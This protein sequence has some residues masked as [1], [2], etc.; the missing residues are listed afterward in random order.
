MYFL[1]ECIIEW[2]YEVVQTRYISFRRTFGIAQN[3]CLHSH[4][5]SEAWIF[6]CRLGPI[7]TSK[8][9]LPRLRGSREKRHDFPS[10]IIIPQSTL[11][12]EM[13]QDK[14]W[15]SL[16]LK[17]TMT[18]LNLLYEMIRGQID[19]DVIFHSEV[20]TRGSQRYRYRQDNETKNIYFYSFF[21]RTIRLWNN[22]PAVIVESKS[23][24]IFNYELLPYLAKN[25]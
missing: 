11:L 15:T 2:T 10:T 9:T 23:F 1:S 5:S 20:G 22:L 18:R 8:R 7:H 16:Q 4:S 12:T 21:S 25:H 13:L 3:E 14:R 17:R 19:I 24:A 6:L